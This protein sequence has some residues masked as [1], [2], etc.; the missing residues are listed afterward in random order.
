MIFEAWITTACFYFVICFG[1]S[2]V[3][4]RLERRSR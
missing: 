1:L 4:A 3:F 2:R